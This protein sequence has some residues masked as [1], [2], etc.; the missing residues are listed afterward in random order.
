MLRSCHV[1][2][3]QGRPVVQTAV[4]IATT[5]IYVE[6]LSNVIIFTILHFSFFRRL[7]LHSSNYRD[8]LDTD[9]ILHSSH[10]SLLY[11]H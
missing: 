2:A 7:L 6:S 9:A 5:V 8:R 3:L 4:H 11:L 1:N 10:H